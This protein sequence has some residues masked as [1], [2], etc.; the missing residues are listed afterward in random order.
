MDTVR[1]VELLADSALFEGIQ[2]HHVRA[3][4]GLATPQG[5]QAGETIV[6]QGESADALYVLEQGE[7]RI[8]Y[9]LSS[10]AQPLDEE[11]GARAPTSEAVFAARERGYPLGWSA[12]VDPN[13]YRATATALTPTQTL[14][15]NRTQLEAYARAHPDFALAFARRALWLAGARLGTVRLGLVAN[16]LRSQR[17]AIAALLAQ[18]APTLPVTSP[19]HH[20]PH[21]LGHR[22]TVD[23]AL[24]SLDALV[25]EGNRV[26]REVAGLVREQLHDIRAALMLFRSLRRIYEV[27]ASAPPEWPAEEIRQRSLLE[28]QQLFAGTRHVIRGQENLPARPGHIF[29][30]N[31]LVNHPDNLLPNDFIL[32]LDTH[33]VASMIL[34]PHYG[35]AP[36]RV[37]RKSHPHEHGHQRYFDRLGYIYVYSGHVEEDSEPGPSPDD[38]RRE[39]LE[40]AAGHL[41]AGRNIVICPEGT[42][43][44]TERS[45]VAF[46]AGAFRLA[47]LTRPEPLIVPIAVANFDK[48]IAQ[49]RTAAV[50]GRPW[51]LSEHVHP[52]ASDAVL[53]DFVNGHAHP[54]MAKMVRDAERLAEEPDPLGVQR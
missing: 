34:L 20:I 44:P 37:V 23:T 48:R 25:R 39:F 9:A 19:L 33:F 14:R 12:A 4:A 41:A 27:V 36:I 10:S 5:F 2:P 31:H 26:E 24:A 38:R 22:L 54:L 43:V 11:E 15:V 47:R 50:V 6:V 45:P 7:V 13:V 40:T 3:V 1:E 30:M 8:A 21:L 52:D 28:F 51:R 42:S 49:T 32:T 17:E 29:V 18:Y 53:H 46:R 16:R 35:Q